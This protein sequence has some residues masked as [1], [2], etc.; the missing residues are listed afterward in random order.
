MALN[1][2]TNTTFPSPPL[3]STKSCS[4]ALFSLATHMTLPA[5]DRTKEAVVDDIG[6]I[7]RVLL[8]YGL[9]PNFSFNVLVNATELCITTPLLT[10]L[11][12]IRT[13][14][15]HHRICTID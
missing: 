11:H 2:S 3:Q 1:E 9:A 15:F 13:M 8:L 14:S 6:N 4:E 12:E 7:L 5:F 10:I